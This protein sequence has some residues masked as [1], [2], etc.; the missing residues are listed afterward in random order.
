MAETSMVILRSDGSPIRVEISGRDGSLL[1]GVAND[2]CDQPIQ[3]QGCTT[4]Q[5]C[6]ALEMLRYKLSIEGGW[7]QSGLGME[8]HM[9]LAALPFPATTRRRFPDQCQEDLAYRPIEGRQDKAKPE[10]SKST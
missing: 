5:A 10:S 1:M 7:V 6:P 4:S 8:N 9:Q 3:K 2:E